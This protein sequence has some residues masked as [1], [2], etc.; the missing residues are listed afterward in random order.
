MTK[1]IVMILCIPTIVMYVAYFIKKEHKK[2]CHFMFPFIAGGLISLVAV[3][4]RSLINC[5]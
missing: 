2:G 1:G 5:I 4:F 3:F